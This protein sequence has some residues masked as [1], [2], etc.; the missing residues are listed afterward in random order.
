MSVASKRITFA[1]NFCNLLKQNPKLYVVTGEEIFHFLSNNIKLMA[2]APQWFSFS[3]AFMCFHWLLV[4]VTLIWLDA[5]INLVLV[6]DITKTY[7]LQAYSLTSVQVCSMERW[8]M[9]ANLMWGWIGWAEGEHEAGLEGFLEWTSD[10]F[11]FF[12]T[13]SSCC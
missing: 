9:V 1:P 12:W 13:S 3:K 10:V 2:V 6:L 7:A 4:T 5:V 11:V 8:L